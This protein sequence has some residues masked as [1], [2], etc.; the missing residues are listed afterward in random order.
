M[1]GVWAKGCAYEHTSISVQH[2]LLSCPQWEREGGRAGGDGK[3][4]KG[5]PT[6][7]TRSD[8]RDKVNSENGAITVG[9][10]NVTGEEGAHARCRE[11]G[12]IRVAERKWPR[13]PQRGYF[14]KQTASEG[15][16]VSKCRCLHRPFNHASRLG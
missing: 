13:V 12:G 7:K 3:G 14:L 11:G 6:N 16:M 8:G 5:G 1:P 15:G 2:V 4:C 10:S 9:Q